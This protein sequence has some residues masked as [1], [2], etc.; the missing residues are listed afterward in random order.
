MNEARSP[1]YRN[2]ACPDSW[3]G[4]VY[5]VNGIP[6]FDRRSSPR[7]AFERARA[8]HPEWPT[9]TRT[10]RLTSGWVGDPSFF[11]HPWVKENA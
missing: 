4:E 2:E 1:Q 6:H 9:L 7:G 5:L 11:T 3:R 8:E 10:T